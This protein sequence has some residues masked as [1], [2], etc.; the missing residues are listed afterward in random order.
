M[1]ITKAQRADNAA[2]LSSPYL[3]ERV[4]ELTQGD[5]WEGALTPSGRAELV[6]CQDELEKR[7]IA[8]GFLEKEFHGFRCS[9]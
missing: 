3:L 7:L 6:A 1:S 5:D 8:C 9:N 2:L 4:I